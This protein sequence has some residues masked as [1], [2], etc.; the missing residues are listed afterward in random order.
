MR[1]FV[2]CVTAFQLQDSTDEPVD[3]AVTL[4][5]VHGSGHFSALYKDGGLAIVRGDDPAAVA[6][7]VYDDTYKATGWAHLS[8]RFP[9][10]SDASFDVRMYAAGL[11]EGLVSATHISE[12]RHNANALIDVSAKQ[13]PGAR[14]VI[15]D[16][17]QAQTETIRR[18][19]NLPKGPPGPL[20]TDTWWAQ[21]RY[22]LL[23]AKG[24]QDGFNLRAA[25]LNTKNMTFIDLMM[26]SSDGET[27]ELMVAYDMQEYLMRQ[28]ERDGDMFLQRNSQLHA[29]QRLRSK[30]F[31]RQLQDLDDDKWREIM[32][33]SGRCSALVRLTD[34]DLLVGHAT[35]SDYAEMS[36]VFK[37]YDF[38]LP[39]VAA[40][41]VGFSSYPGVSGSTDDFYLLSSGLSI[42]E[43][44]IS[45]LTDEPYDKIDDPN[46]RQK[47]IPDFMRIMVSNRLAHSGPEWVSFMTQSETGTY[48]S[49]WMVIDYNKF[50]KGQSGVPKDT[51]WVLEQVPGM[52]H[53]EDMSATLNA[54]K[55]WASYNRAWFPEVRDAIG[56]TTA[57]ELHGPLFSRD[58]SPRANIFRDAQA[59][60]K[61]LA[62]MR[63]IMR[64]NHWPHEVDGGV[65]NTPDHAIAARSDLD[66]QRPYASGAVDAK[67]T[68]SSLVKSLQCEA[69]CGPP[70]TEDHK[71]FSW[72]DFPSAP[73]MGLANTFNFTWVKM[74]PDGEVP[75]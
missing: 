17:F 68:S 75:V 27:P 29:L 10:S 22:A 12:F 69:I 9:E 66:V 5:H 59:G 35:F 20:P 49:Q 14:S 72:D 50:E 33:K 8:V 34:D 37:Y 62:D 25:D 4:D 11:L 63:A 1:F 57:E 38:P 31:K 7:C 43:T 6:T 3:I 36:R 28:N 54:Q 51:L 47:K 55:Y 44:T 73:H 53:S 65:A 58:K 61:T 71:P 56:A 70:V 74:T 30:R 32:R 16:V 39:N 48:S 40:R 67:I 18:N 21:A 2:A 52:S 19:G 41:A 64:R 23:Q 15:H 26:L 13:H 42:T 24:I 45:M 60:V 46:V